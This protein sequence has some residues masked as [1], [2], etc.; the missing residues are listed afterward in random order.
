MI[1]HFVRAQLS[2]AVL[3]L[4]GTVLAQGD[5]AAPSTSPP[6]PSPAPAPA[7][8]APPHGM[9]APANAAPAPGDNEPPA[10]PPRQAGAPAPA[11]YHLDTS[12]R[13]YFVI[14]GVIVFGVAYALGLVAARTQPSESPSKWLL[15][16][17]AGP[18]IAL[19]DLGNYDEQACD[20]RSTGDGICPSKNG[21]RQAYPILGVTQ[22]IGTGL[23]LL[24]VLWPARQWVRDSPGSTGLIVAPTY[25]G[26]SLSGL[27]VAGRF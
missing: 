5:P 26:R 4:G 12:V 16:P 21:A 3:L 18:W 13:R 25:S 7:K 17:V 8:P 9:P 11:G 15:I 14:P 24:G 6:E 22:A 1:R 27:S 23:V 20:R 2:A 19:A 10:T